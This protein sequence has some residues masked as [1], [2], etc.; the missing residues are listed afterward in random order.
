MDAGENRASE[1]RALSGSRSAARL[2]LRRLDSLAWLVLALSVLLSAWFGYVSWS[3]ARRTAEA[4]FNARSEAVTAAI[5]TRIHAYEDI[6]RAAAGMLEAN[7]QLDQY[8]FSGYVQKLQLAKGHPGV[9][10]LGF[11]RRVDSS[12]LQDYLVAQRAQH[13]PGFDVHPHAQS[14]EHLI[15]ELLYPDIPDMRHL[16]GTDIS[17]EPLRRAALKVA[18]DSGELAAAPRVT[19]GKPGDPDSFTGFLLYAPVYTQTAAGRRGTEYPQS[20]P[21]QLLQGYTSAGFGW[22]RMIQE[23]ISG[24]DND[25]LD[26]QLESSDRAVG[27]V[28]QRH[29][30]RDRYGADREPAFTHVGELKFF[31]S[32]WQLRISSAPRN[33]AIAGI[34]SIVILVCSGI[35]LGLMVFVLLST[36]ARADLRSRALL[37]AVADHLPTLIAYIDR[38]RVYG[39]ANRASRDW[40]GAHATSWSERRVADVHADDP[41]FLEA[42]LSAMVESGTGER[43]S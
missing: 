38:N 41:E 2:R 22:E 8:G 42:L 30:L 28:Y 24:V 10:T 16:L 29:A 37:N 25:E 23:A 15:V 12:K 21:Q 35:A 7:P 3:Q 32:D 11:A 1:R 18:R 33:V 40:F 9:Q 13:G 36:L 31:G 34:A 26:L 4:Q 6:V 27:I 17:A 39:F 43:V 5:L 19:F 20:R 14:N